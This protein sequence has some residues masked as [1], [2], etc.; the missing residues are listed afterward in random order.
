MS[1]IWYNIHNTYNGGVFMNC[2]KNCIYSIR[3]QINRVEGE[4]LKLEDFAACKKKDA[5]HNKCIK[6]S[7]LTSI[8]YSMTESLASNADTYFMDDNIDINDRKVYNVF[9]NSLGKPV[10]T[11]NREFLSFDLFPT[12][13]ASIGVKIENNRLGL[14]TNLFSESETLAEKYG[15][16]YVNLQLAKKSVYYNKKLLIKKK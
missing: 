14:G 15:T 5:F 12:T 6:I 3:Q 9:I 16:E 1:I 11:T 2:L 4:L 10:N 8:L 7:N 13:L